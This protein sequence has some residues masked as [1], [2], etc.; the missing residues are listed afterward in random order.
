MGS[1]PEGLSFAVLPV[2]VAVGLAI[3]IVISLPILIGSLRF[4][5]G[6]GV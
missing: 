2:I 1:Q 5:R 3:L 6:V 4:S